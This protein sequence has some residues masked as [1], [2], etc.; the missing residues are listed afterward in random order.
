MCV[1]YIE[2]YQPHKI[3]SY[4]LISCVC[5]ILVQFQPSFEVV[6]WFIV[7]LV[8]HS[9]YVSYFPLDFCMVHVIGYMYKPYGVG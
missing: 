4:R 3:Y 5:Y 9:G 2:L 7:T 6:I 8:I 1:W